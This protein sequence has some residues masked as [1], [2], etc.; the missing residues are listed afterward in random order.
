MA[1]SDDPEQVC[2]WVDSDSFFTSGTITK[3]VP[4]LKELP[5]RSLVAKLN[6]PDDM[7][8]STFINL[9]LAADANYPNN[10]IPYSPLQWCASRLSILFQ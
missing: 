4:T 1:Y 8:D 5:M 7:S 10:Y 9:I 6:P 2:L 3:L